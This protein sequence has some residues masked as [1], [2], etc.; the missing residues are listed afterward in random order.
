MPKTTK[1]ELVLEAGQ[2]STDITAS[3]STVPAAAL[4]NSNCLMLAAV[5]GGLSPAA[6]CCLTSAA[7]ALAAPSMDPQTPCSS[8]A[9]LQCC[10]AGRA[11]RAEE[12]SHCQY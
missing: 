11:M 3:F 1:H 9:A 6:W 10:I 8:C 12:K 4:R 2:A 7:W 5:S